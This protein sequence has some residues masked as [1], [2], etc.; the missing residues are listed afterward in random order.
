MKIIEHHTEFF[1]ATILEWKHLLKQEK[2]TEIII[3]SL[4]FLVQQKRIVVYGFVIMS[5]HIHIIWQCLPNNKP[6]EI[7]LSFMKYTAQMIIKDLRNNHPQVLA[8]FRV[9][10][11]DRKYQI[12]ERNPL[13]IELR[14]REVLEQKLYY[15]HQNPVKA[16]LCLMPEDYI[17]SSAAY[18]HCIEKNKWNFITYY[19]QQ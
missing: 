11:K 4:E 9:D 1:T 13:S 14:S 7:Q 19:N 18:Y 6:K 3:S 15:I 8:H 5:N 12:W 17:F 10:S 16:N 2:Y